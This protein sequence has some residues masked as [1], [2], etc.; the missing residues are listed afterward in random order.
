TLPFLLFSPSTALDMMVF[1]HFALACLGMWAYLRLALRTSLWASM[2]GALCFTGGA[3]MLGHIILGNQLQVICLMPYLFLCAHFALE[4]RRLRW[5]VLTAVAIG[6]AFLAGHPEEW[7]YEMASL[8]A[9]GGAWI[10]FRDRGGILVRL[11]Q[12]VLTLGGAVVLF[13]LLFSWQLLPTMLLKGQGYRNSP[14]FNQ[15]YPVPRAT[16]ING[17]LPDFGKV[18][19][20]EQEAV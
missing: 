15:Q 19:G 1:T 18:R 2:L 9:Y 16:P 20:G 17:L 12:A 3:V 8:A 13:V 5:V 7:L 14:S 11:R 10:L 6:M 4:R